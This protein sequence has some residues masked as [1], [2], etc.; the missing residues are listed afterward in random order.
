VALFENNNNA[1][2]LISTDAGEYQFC[3]FCKLEDV[4]SKVGMNKILPVNT[5]IY[6]YAQMHLD[7]R[8]EYPYPGGWEHQPVAFNYLVEIAKAEIVMIRKINGGDNVD[9]SRQ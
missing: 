1:A 2:A 9:P 8:Y 7:R 3:R 4:C 5:K 6:R